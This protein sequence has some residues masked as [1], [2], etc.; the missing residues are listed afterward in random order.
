MP[1]SLTN[2]SSYAEL[3]RHDNKQQREIKLC[4][5]KPQKRQPPVESS[6]LYWLSSRLMFFFCRV[7]SLFVVYWTQEN[8]GVA[9]VAVVEP[10][11]P[12]KK[13]RLAMPLCLVN[14]IKLTFRVHFP[15][16]LL[17]VLSIRLLFEWPSYRF[18]YI[19][20]Q[21]QINMVNFSVSSIVRF[22]EVLIKN[23]GSVEISRCSH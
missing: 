15:S 11:P 12:K 23:N 13:H 6:S 8:A 5:K 1:V 2:E 7:L 4:K 3:A 21:F 17:P 9:A 10:P 16:Y 20:G 18:L 14:N 19:R 22:T